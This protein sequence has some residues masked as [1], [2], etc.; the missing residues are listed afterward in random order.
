[1]LRCG[2]YLLARV[3]TASVGDGAVE[4]HTLNT[5]YLTASH[6]FGLFVYLLVLTNYFLN[7]ISGVFF[8]LLC[9]TCLFSIRL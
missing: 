8:K 4:S 1:M 2:L 6:S 9:F 3:V 5:P 7:K